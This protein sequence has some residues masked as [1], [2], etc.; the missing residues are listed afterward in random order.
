MREFLASVGLENEV[1]AKTTE[2]LGTE[3]VTVEEPET[4]VD[5]ED[6]QGIGIQKSRDRSHSAP[7]TAK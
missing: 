2:I 5:D 4:V 1:L 7:P 3:G 6:L